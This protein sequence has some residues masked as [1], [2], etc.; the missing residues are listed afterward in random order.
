MV[1]LSKAVA[2]AMVHG[3]RAGLDVLD[4]INHRRVRN[5]RLDAVRAHLLEML[6]DDRE[7]LS[8]YRLAAAGATNLAERRRLTARAARLNDRL[9]FA[10]ENDRP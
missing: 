1:T 9:E 4:G 6:G 2:T 8:C 5:F 10:R 7:A 3:P